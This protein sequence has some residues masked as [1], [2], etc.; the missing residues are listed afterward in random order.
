MHCGMVSYKYTLIIA[1][2]G[3]VIVDEAAAMYIQVT[4]LPEK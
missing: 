1:V 3:D 2:C 4:I